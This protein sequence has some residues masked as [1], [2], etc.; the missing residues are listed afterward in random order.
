MAR[1]P[2]VQQPMT[3]GD[4]VSHIITLVIIKGWLNKRSWP[5]ALHGL[6]FFAF[7][8]FPIRK[9]SMVSYC[10]RTQKNLVRHVG[11]SHKILFVAICRQCRNRC[12]SLIPYKL[13]KCNSFKFG[14]PELLFKFK[15]FSERRTNAD[16]FAFLIST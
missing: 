8:Q 13:G 4:K 2:L 12:N 3:N 7:R 1:P 16:C 15:S 11:G 6:I 10:E 9:C 5:N 14:P